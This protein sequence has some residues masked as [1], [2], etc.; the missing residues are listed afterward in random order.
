MHIYATYQPTLTVILSDLEQK[1][2]KEAY[3][4]YYMDAWRKHRA[5]YGGGME[6]EVLA[7]LDWWNK[8]GVE[9][10]G[11]MNCYLLRD[12][13]L[14]HFYDDNSEDAHCKK[15]VFINEERNS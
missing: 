12:N 9:P 4:H 5:Q 8:P 3:E 13:G 7:K 15:F 2:W 10:N 14:L 11:Y 6:E 1:A